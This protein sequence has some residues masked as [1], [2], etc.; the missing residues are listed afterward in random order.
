MELRGQVKQH[1]TLAASAF[2]AA[3]SIRVQAVGR[4]QLVQRRLRNDRLR[5]NEEIRGSDHDPRN[6]SEYARTQQKVGGNGHGTLPIHNT[7]W[8]PHAER[9]GNSCSLAERRR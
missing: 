5:L 2:G 6:K 1:G 3:E 7:H 4:N 8:A 9:L